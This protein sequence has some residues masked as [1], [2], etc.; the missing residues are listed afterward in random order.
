MQFLVIVLVW[1][2]LTID[3]E[4][5]KNWLLRGYLFFIFFSKVAGLGF[6]V[7]TSQYAKGAAGR[8]MKIKILNEIYLTFTNKNRGDLYP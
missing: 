3:T 2:F 1:S 4:S 6:F 8:L 5:V 7:K